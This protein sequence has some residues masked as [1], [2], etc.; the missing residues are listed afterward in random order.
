LRFADYQCKLGTYLRGHWGRQWRGVDGH[1][2][3]W[4]TIKDY[5]VQYG[6]PGHRMDIGYIARTT[7]KFYSTSHT[8]GHVWQPLAGP[9]R[10]WAGDKNAKWLENH[11]QPSSFP[12]RHHGEF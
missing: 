8:C 3:E 9:K 11:E 2:D 4:G 10:R 7:H 12:A 1:P 6:G 5:K